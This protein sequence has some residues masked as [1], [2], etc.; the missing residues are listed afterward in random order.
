MYVWMSARWGGRIVAPQRRGNYRDRGQVR[1]RF[2]PASPY[3][4]RA[5]VLSARQSLGSSPVRACGAP[6]EAWMLA[7]SRHGGVWGKQSGVWRR[8]SGHVAPIGT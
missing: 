8:A 2:A 6:V 3:V 4:A 1:S 5:W 7:C